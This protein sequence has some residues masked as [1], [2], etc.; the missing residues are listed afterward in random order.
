MMSRRHVVAAALGIAA[1]AVITQ[2]SAAFTPAA[3]TTRT[4]RFSDVLFASDT[5]DC[6]CG[7]SAKITGAPTPEARAINPR[8]AILQSSV[9]RL[10]GTRVSMSELLPNKNRVSLV[11]LT[12]SFG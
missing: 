8:E 7:N 4:N 10:D 6:G 2:Q 9:M 5:T 12:R 1:A 3:L 11:V